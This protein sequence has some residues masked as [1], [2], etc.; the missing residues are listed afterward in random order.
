MWQTHLGKFVCL[1][2]LFEWDEVL[3]LGEEVYCD[4]KLYIIVSRKGS[5]VSGIMNC[6]MNARCPMA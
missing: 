2:M 5:M 4:N 6:L 3:E 1:L